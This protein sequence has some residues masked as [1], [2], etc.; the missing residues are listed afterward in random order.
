M[1]KKASGWV[2]EEGRE[3]GREGGVYMSIFQ[4]MKL[5]D[6]NYIPIFTLYFLS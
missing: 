5:N 1:S 2:R 4:I 3:G 6:I